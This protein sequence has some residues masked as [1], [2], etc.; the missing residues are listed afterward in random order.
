MRYITHVLKII[1]IGFVALVTLVGML[2]GI[3]KLNIDWMLVYQVAMVLFYSGTLGW[4][5]YEAW[6]L[7][8][9]KPVTDFIRRHMWSR[10]LINK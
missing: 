3:S 5:I 4:L 6:R 7:Y 2:Y 8:F 9:K 10:R 1:L